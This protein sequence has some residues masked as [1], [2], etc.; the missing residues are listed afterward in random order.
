MTK[1]SCD[2]EHTGLYVARIS[3]ARARTLECTLR[4]AIR[5][6]MQASKGFY[7]LGSFPWYLKFGQIQDW[8][9]N[10]DLVFDECLVLC[11]SG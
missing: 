10:P 6:M 1:A 4:R 3:V 7:E 5:V 9:Y 2:R 8:L 11:K